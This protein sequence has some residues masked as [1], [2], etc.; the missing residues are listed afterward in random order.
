MSRNRISQLS[1]KLRSHIFKH[2]NR[3]L[4][5]SFVA[6]ELACFVVT[7]WRQIGGSCR[8]HVVELVVEVR[9][10]LDEALQPVLLV[11]HPLGFCHDA[12]TTVACDG[13]GTHA[14]NQESFVTQVGCRCGEIFS[15]VNVL[16][17]LGG[18]LEACFDLLECL[19]RESLIRHAETGARC[20]VVFGR[21]VQANSFSPSGETEVEDFKADRE[22]L[23]IGAEGFCHSQTSEACD[24]VFEDADERNDA[25]GHAGNLHG[26]RVV[27][28]QA[29]GGVG[30]DLSRHD[31]SCFLSLMIR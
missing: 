11:D 17:G 30:F 20:F 27:G 2:C 16:E 25:D 9:K 4:L 28:L 18:I 23:D 24:G 29:V 12:G 5:E 19:D 22:K 31:E 14:L 8:Q 3:R 26:P 13:H 21:F 10:I 1:V 7:D 6:E 15:N